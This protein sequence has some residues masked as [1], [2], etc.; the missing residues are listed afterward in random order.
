MYIVE[1]QQLWYNNIMS[2]RTRVEG[3]DLP[4]LLNHINTALDALELEQKGDIV[5]T[6][7][8][9][10]ETDRT[11]ILGVELLIPVDKVFE[12]NSR[13]VY[14]SCFK[15]ENAVMS[16]FNGK[17][18]K[19]KGFAAELCSYVDSSNIKPITDVYY[20]VRSICDDDCV[21]DLYL[22]TSGNIL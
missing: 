18:C 7:D 19:L 9:K 17:I 10:V 4:Q 22:G 11:T 2:Y 15:L 12:S 21:I 5:F 8:E 1:K 3:K 20:L 13:Y 14:K 16:K 6:I